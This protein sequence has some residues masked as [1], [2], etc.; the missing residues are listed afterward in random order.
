RGGRAGFD[1]ARRGGRQRVGDRGEHAVVLGVG[2]HVLVRVVVLQLPVRT[3]LGVVTGGGELL[4]VEVDQRLPAARHD[5]VVR[6]RQVSVR[7]VEVREQP[8]EHLLPPQ[9]HRLRERARH[10]EVVGRGAGRRPV[11]VVLDGRGGCRDGAF[12]GHC[13]SCDTDVR[14]RQYRHRYTV[15][16]VVPGRV[17]RGAPPERSPG[18]VGTRTRSP[19]HGAARIVPCARASVTW[20]SVDGRDG[21]V[22]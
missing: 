15:F 20:W 8:D 1:A 5:L 19:V 12:G 3:E 11:E 7:I 9:G 16:G 4:L 6:P 10:H 21:A 2:H 17:A 22:A 13:Y 18:P 14:T